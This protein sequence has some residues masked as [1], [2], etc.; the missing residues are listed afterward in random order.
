MMENK[1]VPVH[2][3]DELVAVNME[4]IEMTEQVQKET[5]LGIEQTINEY[6]L[7][8]FEQGK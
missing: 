5:L 3:I 2:W 6:V 1:R 4:M 7:N 8:Q